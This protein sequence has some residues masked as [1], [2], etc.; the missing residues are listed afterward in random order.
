MDAAKVG[1][2]RLFQVEPARA[3]GDG[4]YRY[5]RGCTGMNCN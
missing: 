4:A 2:P 5:E 1:V 3:G